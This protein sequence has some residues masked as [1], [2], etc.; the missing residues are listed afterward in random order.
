MASW[1]VADL[2][3]AVAHARAAGFTVADAATGVLPGTRVA[4]VQGS[5]L[6]GVNVQLLQYV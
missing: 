2:D 1:Q 3:A 4:T 6:A 5:E